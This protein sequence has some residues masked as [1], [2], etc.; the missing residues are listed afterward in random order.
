[1]TKKEKILETTLQLIA[2]NGLNASPMSM[3]AKEANVA[4]GT[5]YHHFKSKEEI[6]NEIYLNKKKDFKKILDRYE[7]DSL[8]FE[9]K[10]VSI[11]TDFY[12]Y[13]VENPLNF[14]FT[15]QISFSP[16]ITPEVKEEGESY[17][18]SIFVFF[19][20]NE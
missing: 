19:Q 6:I 11:W 4:T 18:S 12:N 5:I 8:S 16:I 13:F 10:F 7:D 9:K 15:Q 3:I 1:M 17:Y 2:K 14:T 20:K